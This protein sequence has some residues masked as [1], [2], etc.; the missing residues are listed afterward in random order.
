MLLL[1]WLPAAA[2]SGVHQSHQARQ[3]LPAQRVPSPARLA[4]QT[5]PRLPL[6]QLLQSQRTLRR[7]APHLLLQQRQQQ[8]LRLLG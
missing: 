8:L 2:A 4:L 7:P 3:Q 6:R 1:T 5:A